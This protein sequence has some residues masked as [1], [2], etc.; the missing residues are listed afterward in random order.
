MPNNLS[1]ESKVNSRNSFEAIRELLTVGLFPGE[2]AEHLAALKQYLQSLVEHID[3]D[4][5]KS[6]ENASTDNKV[7]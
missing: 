5:S 4:I 1:T 6:S 7:E 3:Q 2:C